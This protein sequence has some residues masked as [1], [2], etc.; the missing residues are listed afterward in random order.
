MLWAGLMA[1][2]SSLA[3]TFARPQEPPSAAALRVLRDYPSVDVH[4]HGGAT[5][6]SSTLGPDDALA[7]GMRAGGLTAACLAEVA[8]GP[9][10][11]RDSKGVLRALREPNRGELYQHHLNRLDWFDQLVA[12]HGVRRV[13]N[14]ADLRAAHAAGQPAVIQDSEGMDFLEGKLERLEECHRRGVRHAQLVHYAPNAIGDFQTGDVRHKGLSPFGVE[15]IRA[16]HRLGW[17]VDVAH[18]TAEMVAQAAQVAT[19]P[20]LLSHTALRGSKAQGQTPLTERQ[21]TPAHAK[22]VAA[23]GGAIG[24]WHFFPSLPAYV[25]GIREMADVVGVDHVCIGTDNS[26]NPGGTMKDLGA[27]PRL[28]DLMLKS[29][30]TAAEAGKIVGGNYLRIFEASSKAG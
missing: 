18:G 19:R 1:S 27:L 17:V 30:F 3:A 13:L 7:R 22:I 23:T 24:L 21:I 11:G 2:A 8:D 15:V 20:L 9:L 14:P 10:L 25:D 29:G 28:V 4:T 5:G 26:T 12:R 6:I 16:C